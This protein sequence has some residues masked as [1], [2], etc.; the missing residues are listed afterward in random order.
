[1]EVQ[2][3]TVDVHVGNS[4]RG[5]RLLKRLSQSALGERIGVTYQQIQKY[6]RGSNR[7]SASMLVEIARALEI[8]VRIIFDGLASQTGSTVAETV[9]DDQP[10]RRL[11]KEPREVM[12]LSAAFLAISNRGLRRK[13]LRLVQTIAGTE[14]HNNEADIPDA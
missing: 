5:Q 6:E 2:P 4:I 10:I 8:D 1:M 9:N 11:S 12:L 13:I 7:V 14:P 3:H